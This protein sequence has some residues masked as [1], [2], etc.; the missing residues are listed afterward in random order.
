MKEFGV[1]PIGKNLARYRKAEGLSAAELA[2]KVG[3]GLSRSV[4]A[5]LENGRKDDITVRQLIALANVLRVPPAVLVVD[6]FSPGDDSPYPMPTADTYG[7]IDLDSFEVVRKPGR[8]RNSEF[9]TWF[10][11][12]STLIPE[13]QLEGA[14]QLAD[15]AI[16]KLRGYQ[17][18][19]RRYANALYR[20]TQSLDPITREPLIPSDEINALEKDLSE[21][22]SHVLRWVREMK[23]AGIKNEAAEPQIRGAMRT[24]RI[25]LADDVREDFDG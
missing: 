16:Q 15:D 19:W 14:S 25:S 11:A 2:E 18:A 21:E 5:N 9:L 22:A 12:Q 24:L 1:S 3:E 20:V 8:S 7:E 17:F 10:G 4:I 23:R 13:D 6:L